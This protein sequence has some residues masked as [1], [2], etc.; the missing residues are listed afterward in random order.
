MI[1]TPEQMEDIQSSGSTYHAAKK[2]LADKNP[3]VLYNVKSNDQ[4]TIE[5]IALI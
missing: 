4:Q 1:P 5:D 2:M 3:E